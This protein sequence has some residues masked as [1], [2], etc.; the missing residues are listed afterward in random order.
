[1][2]TSLVKFSFKNVSPGS[3]I[4]VRLKIVGDFGISF[5]EEDL[6][7]FGLESKF[8][9]KVEWNGLI[10]GLIIESVFI[11]F[12]FSFGTFSGDDS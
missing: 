12:D 6:A 1:M 11:D 7:P 3:K 5:L 8:E 4:L 10:G 2:K 9:I